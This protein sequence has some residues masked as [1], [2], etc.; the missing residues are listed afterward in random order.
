MTSTAIGFLFI[1]VLNFLL[2]FKVLSRLYK[3]SS[4]PPTSA[5]GFYRHKPKY[6][7]PKCG[8]VNNCSLEDSS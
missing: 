7:P 3:K 2:E 8:I 5:D 6:F 4:N 1:L